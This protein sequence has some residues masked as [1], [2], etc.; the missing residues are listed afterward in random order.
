MNDVVLS[1]RLT[2]DPELKETATIKVAYYGLAVQRKKKAENGDYEVDFI[3]CKAFGKNADFA[4][5][6]LHKGTKMIV[7]GSIRTGKYTNK[8]GVQVNTFEVVVDDQEFA[9]SKA[10][11]E[12]HAA[13]T[14]KKPSDDFMV[15]PD[16]L[17]DPG[18][19]FV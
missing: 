2:R 19:P 14:G 5:N 6:Y 4:Q 17:D 3:N 16:A 11:A 8:D 7:R 1:G 10:V 9:E 15:V 13:E 12:Q 18:L